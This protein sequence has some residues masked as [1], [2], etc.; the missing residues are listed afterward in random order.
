[1]IELREYQQEE[2]EQDMRTLLDEKG[3]SGAIKVYTNKID[4]EVADA[5]YVLN[6]TVQEYLC[7]ILFLA[8]EVERRTD[9]QTRS[10]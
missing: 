2:Y 1:M 3:L 5:G 6:R 4:E 8:R 7:D 10:N 9:G